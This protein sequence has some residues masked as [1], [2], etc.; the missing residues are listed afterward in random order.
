M[1]VLGAHYLPFV[2]LY[3]MQLFGL[4]A[5]G[6]VALGLAM[7][8]RT[9]GGW[10]DPAWVTGAVLLLFSVAGWMATRHER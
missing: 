4:L 1:V 5:F 7:S 9:T 6:L 2:F 8:Q 3:G 10:A